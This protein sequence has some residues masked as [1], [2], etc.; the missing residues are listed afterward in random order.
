MDPVSSENLR[1]FFERVKNAGL[2]ERTFSWR[3]IQSQGETA[4][5]ECRQLEARI[6]AMEQEIES[7]KGEAVRLGEELRLAA[8]TLRKEIQKFDLYSSITRHD[9]LNYLTGLEGFIEITGSLVSDPDIALYIGKEREMAQAIRKQIG[10]TRSYQDIGKP[11]G[12]WQNVNGCIGKTVANFPSHHISVAVNCPPDLE[13]F[14]DPLLGKVLDNLLD[15]SLR[16]GERVKEIHVS[17]HNDGGGLIIVWEDD[18]VGIAADQMEKIFERGPARAGLTLFLTRE[19]LDVTGITIRETG[20]Y[21]KG[22]RFEMRVPEGAYR[23]TAWSD[24]GSG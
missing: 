14:A 16:Y 4:I 8:E 2:S 21:G 19:V 17:S 11:H 3:S 18:G 10:G 6:F 20:T 23:F 12:T 15:N 24:S 7:R 13:I 22:A 9:V 5:A 1:S